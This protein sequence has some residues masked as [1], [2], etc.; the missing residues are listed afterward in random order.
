MWRT[1]SNAIREHSGFA[2]RAAREAIQSTST[3]GLR[4]LRASTTAG[5][6]QS[7]PSV[8]RLLPQEN[9]YSF[10]GGW[11]D[12]D[13]HAI[14]DGFRAGVTKDDSPKRAPEPFIFGG[15][16]VAHAISM[17]QN[18]DRPFCMPKRLARSRASEAKRNGINGG[19]PLAGS[20]PFMP[21]SF[22]P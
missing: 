3:T 7:H 16:K 9:E 14:G 22:Y 13:K 18:D 6:S 10:Q 17:H 5:L 20:R 11:R 21:N 12:V 8:R 19:D 2:L 15:F 1:I 4:W